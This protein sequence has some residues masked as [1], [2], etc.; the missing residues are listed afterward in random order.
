LL[1]YFRGDGCYS[2]GKITTVSES[3][4]YQL[5]LL[6]GML[7]IPTGFMKLKKKSKDLIIGD[8]LVKKEN[9]K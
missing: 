2:N 7:N 8:N 4:A 1:G 6:F 3:L 5:R 9:F